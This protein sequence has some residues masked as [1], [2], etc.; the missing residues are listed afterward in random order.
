MDKVLIL[1]MLTLSGC[2]EKPIETQEVNEGI[3][4]N[5]LPAPL[6]NSVADNLPPDKFSHITKEEVLSY[7]HLYS[8]T[9]GESVEEILEIGSEL[10]LLLDDND[11]LAVEIYHHG[12]FVKVDPKLHEKATLL[13]KSRCEEKQ[14]KNVEF[15]KP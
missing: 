2:S 5:I 11:I 6:G 14:Y 10:N 13:L 9:K 8:I 7:I 3:P 4:E 15:S 12:L 1:L